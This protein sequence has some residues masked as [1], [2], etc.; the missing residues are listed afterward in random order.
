MATALLVNK[1]YQG[2]QGKYVLKVG[3]AQVWL[4]KLKKVSYDDEDILERIFFYIFTVN[5]FTAK[6]FENV[7]FGFFWKEF[8]IIVNKL[9]RFWKLLTFCAKKVDT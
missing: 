8:S 4:F 1:S 2:L 5:I 3:F 9:L 7:A 6:S